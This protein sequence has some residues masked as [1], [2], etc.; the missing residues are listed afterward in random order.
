MIKLLLRTFFILF[1]ITGLFATDYFVKNGGNDGLSGL[2]DTNA[3]ETMAKVNSISFNAGDTI[4]FKRGSVWKEQ[5][6]PQ[7]VSGSEG[8]YITFTDYDSGDLPLITGRDDLAG[9]GTGG[10]WNDVGGDVWY[11][12]SIDPNPLRLFFDGTEYIQADNQGAVD[13][14][15]R[16]WYDS[17]NDRVYV[18]ATENPSTFYSAMI[19]TRGAV[20]GNVAY[21]ENNDYIHLSNLNIQGSY[22][23]IYF[24]KSDYALVEDCTIGLYTCHHG[25]EVRGL[26]SSPYTPSTYGVLRNCDI[27]SG[28]NDYGYADPRGINGDGVVFH[29]S[30]QYW[31]VHNC[32][33]ANWGHNGV[34]IANTE[35]P[36]CQCQHNE[37]YDNY[38][39]G[40]NVRY[41]RGMDYDSYDERDP[42]DGQCAY[43][44]FY[45]NFIRD[46]SVRS[47]IHGD[48]NEFFYNIVSGVRDHGGGTESIACA[49]ALFAA[50][51]QKCHHNKI[52]NNV[53]HDTAEHGIDMHGST[54]DGIKE[55]NEIINNI[56]IDWAMTTPGDGIS[57]LDN[58]GSTVQDNTWKNN[59]LYKSGVWDVVDYRGTPRTAAEF[60]SENGNNGDVI[61]DN[62]SSDPL[63]INA[64]SSFDLDTDFLIPIGS[65]AKD[66][67]I[68]VG[69][70]VDYFG[71]L[72]PSGVAPDIGGHEY[73][74]G[75]AAILRIRDILRIRNVLR[76]K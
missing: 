13:G 35:D 22:T 73:Q 1:M 48:H 17:G 56:I 54:D 52:Y 5:L 45:R 12:G 60:N 28:Y 4:Q 31:K 20:A 16:W 36:N 75:E 62:I 76:I 57:I 6:N 40:E 7:T 68:N 34:N 11:I 15:E 21:F 49:I 69:L 41:M 25:F 27:L 9:W 66:T 39:H 3:W 63:F 53:F 23:G 65:P 18:Y 32:E 42:R 44:K 72:V 55:D 58:S 30:V 46:T 70:T 10:N 19:D 61:A 43:N 38:I 50:E 33:I 51:G 64:G 67:G 29:G 74:Q 2:D 47:Q 8:S 37:A 14:T 59:L 26:E 24:G 71:N